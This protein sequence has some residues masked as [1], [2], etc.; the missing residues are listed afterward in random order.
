M[1]TSVPIDWLSRLLDMMPV[2]GY[3]DLRCVYGAPWRI[4]QD[5]A[6]KGEIPYHIVLGGSALLV[7]PNG[8]AS[9]RLEAGDILLLTDGGA[10]VLHDGSGLQAV[11][12]RERMTLH[13]T[14]SENTGT[15]DRLDMLCGRF[16]F[17]TSHD[18]LVRDYLPGRLVVRAGRKTPAGA[19]LASL[20]AVMRAEAD[21]EGLGGRAMLNALSAALFALTLRHASASDVVPTGLLAIAGDA[22]LAPAIAAMFR[23]PSHPWTLPEL[24]RV[25]NMSRATIARR[26]Q[27]KLG[28]SASDLLF[29]I[30]MT[31]AAKELRETSAS[32]GAVADAVGYQSE[33]AFQRAFR[34]RMGMTP[35]QWRR[36]MRGQD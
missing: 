29:D 12:A 18:R 20:V 35:A 32:T 7:D 8:G 26:F 30:R 3:L 6:G 13:V 4:A 27:D 25:C 10:H 15:G 2:A 28:R 31:L 1:D 22:R 33:A 16:I 34:Q 21:A 19:E 36:A 17:G 23:D 5:R 14:V 9:E 11:P 24:A